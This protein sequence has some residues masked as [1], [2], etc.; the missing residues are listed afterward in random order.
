MAM[1]SA[2]GVDVGGTKITAGRVDGGVL[3]A[4]VTVSTAETAQG[5]LRQIDDL[6]SALDAP[7]VAAIG[8]GAPGR[9]DSATATVLSG[10]YVDL[11][12]LPLNQRL[13][14]LKGRPLFADNDANMALV[15]EARQGAGRGLAHLV[16]LTIGTGI[17]GAAMDSG[18]ILHG[19]GT[20]GEL[21]HIGIDINGEPCLCGRRGCL[22]TA[23]SGTALRRLIAAAGMPPETRVQDLLARDDAAARALIAAWALPLRAG[24]ESLVAA[25]DPQL[26][27]LGGGLGEAAC[28]ALSRFPTVSPWYRNDVAPAQFGNRAGVIGA[29]IAALEALS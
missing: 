29:A 1:L 9:V 8:I 18:R 20:A 24:I 26:V 10:G 16:M 3:A 17:G 6:I 27:V 28:A 13:A 21:G 2:I 23:S 15:G 11:S 14:A 5:V 22:E 7:G 25:F 12:G 19:R 4:E